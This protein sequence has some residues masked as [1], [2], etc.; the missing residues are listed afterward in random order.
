MRISRRSASFARLRSRLVSGT[1]RDV[2]LDGV[3][4]LSHYLRWGKAEGR[5]PLE[6]DHDE[7]LIRSSGL[8]DEAWYV[9]RNPEASQFPGGP[10]QHFLHR[11]AREFRDPNPYFNVAW[12]CARRSNLDPERK[13]PLVHYLEHGSVEGS[14][15]SPDFDIAWY[16]KVYPDA[17]A[18]RR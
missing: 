2:A 18:Q 5:L 6:P 3:E 9:R 15:P 16:K 4:P 17:G 8:F 14:S 10:L 13:N 12:Y 1:Y 7:R 11:G